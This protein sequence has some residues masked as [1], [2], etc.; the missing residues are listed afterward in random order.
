MGL[1]GREKRQCLHNQNRFIGG[2]TQARLGG[3]GVF[4]KE[5]Y[6]VLSNRPHETAEPFKIR[7]WYNQNRALRGLRGVKEE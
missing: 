2:K 5:V 3:P 4:G 7:V 1:K 6:T